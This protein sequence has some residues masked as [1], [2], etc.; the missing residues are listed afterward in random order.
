MEISI[1][2]IK[3]IIITLQPLDFVVFIIQME[4]TIQFAL[5]IAKIEE[6]IYKL[7]KMKLLNVILM[8]KISDV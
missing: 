6:E 3:L 2:K 5:I 1:F 4:S 8:N 7:I